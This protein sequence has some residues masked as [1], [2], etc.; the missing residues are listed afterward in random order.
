MHAAALCG[1]MS[2]ITCMGG[3]I[4]MHQCAQVRLRGKEAPPRKEQDEP[5]GSKVIERAA[6]LLLRRP[7]A[8]L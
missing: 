8:Y 4:H 5:C 3:E 1:G 7:V 6:G 2:C